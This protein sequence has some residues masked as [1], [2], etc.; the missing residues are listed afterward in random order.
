MKISNEALQE[1]I[2]LWEKTY[3]EEIGVK[4]ARKYAHQLLRL[5]KAIYDID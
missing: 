2:A 1:F 5:L 4:K 3:G